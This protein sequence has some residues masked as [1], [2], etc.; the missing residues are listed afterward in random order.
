MF[1]NP[2][3]YEAIT[4]IALYASANCKHPNFKSQVVRAVTDDPTLVG[5]DFGDFASRNWYDAE[6]TRPAGSPSS[7]GVGGC[8]P[9]CL[10]KQCLPETWRGKV[11]VPDFLFDLGTMF[12]SSTPT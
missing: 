12:P 2:L 1:G 11:H 3:D 4:E 6:C 10:G 5:M 9:V 7:N 8:P